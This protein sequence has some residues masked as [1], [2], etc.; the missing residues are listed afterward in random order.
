MQLN[1]IDWMDWG[2]HLC[3]KKMFEFNEWEENVHICVWLRTDQI[4]FCL[5]FW[6]DFG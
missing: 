4:Y 3:K 1:V 2:L 5:F 6:E